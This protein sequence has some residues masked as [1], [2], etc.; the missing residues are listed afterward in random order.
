MKVSACIIA[1][2]EPLLEQCL[3][4]IK[5]YVDEIVVVDTGS[6]DNTPEIA[7]KYADVFEVYTGCNDPKTGLINDFSDARKRSF[8]IA[9]NKAVIWLDADDILVGAENIKKILDEYEKTTSTFDAVGFI[10]PYE[11]SYDQDGNCTCRHYR[12]RLFTDK[13]KFRWTNPVHEVAVPIESYNISLIQKDD[14]IYKHH[15]QYSSKHMESGR[16][17]RILKKYF[18]KVGESDARQMYYLGLEYVNNGLVDES[19]KCLSRYIEISGWEDERVMACLKLV[20]IYHALV[21][22]EKALEWGFKA[23]EI[24][25]NWGEGYFALA[26]TFYFMA[27]RGDAN[28]TRYWQKCAHYA[29]IGLDLPPTQTMLF[30]NP[31]EREAEI[32]KYYNVAL[33]K[34]GDIKGALESVNIGIRKQP[35]DPHLTNNK[36]VYEIFLAK[37]DITVGVNKLNE[38]GGIDKITTNNIISLIN[39]QKISIENNIEKNSIKEPE[40]IKINIW[41]IASEYEKEGF[42]LIDCHLLKNKYVVSNL[43]QEDK[44]SL[45]NIVFFIGDGVEEWTPETVKYTGIG[46]SELMAINISKRLAKLGHNVSIYSGCGEAG[47]G[48]YDGVRYYKT[49]KYHDLSCDVLIVSRRADALDDKYNIKSKIKLLWVHDVFAINATN[50]L[51]AKADR[52]LALSEWHKDNLVNYHNIHPNKIIKTRN[53]IDLKRFN[54]KIERNRFKCINSSSPDRSWPVLL[55]AWPEIKKHV[56]QAELHLYY[57]FKNWKYSA[58]FNPGHNDLINKLEEM[59]VNM[60]DLGVVFHDR[61]SQDKL[62]DEMLGSGAWLYPSWFWETSCIS[63]MEAQAAGLRMITSNR[64]ALTETVGYRGTLIDGEWTSPEYISVFIGKTIEALTKEDQDDRIVLQKYAQDHFDLDD[65][66]NEWNDMLYELIETIKIN[67]ICPYYPT[68]SYR[69]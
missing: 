29:K 30:I 33:S 63:A 1:K 12:E 4:S 59:I 17:L 7:K 45:L 39:N 41:E 15:R 19:I 47:E 6:T 67:P 34:L 26:K 54:K 48:I 14:V 27:M 18:E 24:K 56:P 65:L 57:G 23:I 44:N 28:Q 10:F 69:K 50:D 11:Y 16:N 55:Q 43:L 8:D 53:G 64:G 62:S 35:K 42:K 22:Y 31:L 51:L 40:D 3:K 52:I 5:G 13:N 9:T 60:K 46:G 36:K 32:H 61:I 21:Q 25:E 68:A 37:H 2:N 20:D 66:A 49:E 38:Y 58:Q